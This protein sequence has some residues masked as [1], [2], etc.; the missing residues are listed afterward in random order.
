MNNNT[1]QGRLFKIIQCEIL[2]HEIFAIYGI[3]ELYA[4][5]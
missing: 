1:V 3:H 5:R 2:L 4:D